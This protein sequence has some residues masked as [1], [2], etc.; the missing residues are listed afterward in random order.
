MFPLTYTSYRTVVFLN[1]RSVLVAQ[2]APMPWYSPMVG[3]AGRFATKMRL[4][5]E[6]THGRVFE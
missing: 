5:P 4:Q 3:V 1:R 6:V 2:I